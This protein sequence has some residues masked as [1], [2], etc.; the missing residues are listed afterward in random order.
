[1]C[2]NESTVQQV[3]TYDG[4]LE[5]HNRVQDTPGLPISAPI[6]RRDL[7]FVWA[8]RLCVFQ[9]LE[10]GYSWFRSTPPLSLVAVTP[11]ISYSHTYLAALL[12]Q[13]YISCGLTTYVFGPHDTGQDLRHSPTMERYTYARTQY[14]RNQD[15]MSRASTE[16]QDR[17][18]SRLC[19][20]R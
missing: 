4:K 18:R 13:P 8:K 14:I 3:V 16:E 2:E 12:A 20:S 19:N 17:W 6:W 9:L 11:S 15:T 10:T 5:G 7:S 1:L